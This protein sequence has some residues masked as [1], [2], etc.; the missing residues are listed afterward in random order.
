M[1]RRNNQNSMAHTHWHISMRFQRKSANIM[2]LLEYTIV[3][4]PPDLAQK[5][6]LETSFSFL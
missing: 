1:N 6:L 3:G 2:S 5:R 4:K